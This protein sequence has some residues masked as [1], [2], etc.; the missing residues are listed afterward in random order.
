MIR[1]AD[2]REITVALEDID[3]QKVGGSLMPAGL[4]EDMTRQELVDLVRFLSEL[5][6]AWAVLG[7]PR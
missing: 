5:G 1:D 6:Q 3:E 4:T 7:L 2:D